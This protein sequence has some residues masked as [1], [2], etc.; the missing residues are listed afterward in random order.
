MRIGLFAV[1]A[2]GA[3]LVVAPE[4]ALGQ[5]MFKG[6]GNSPQISKPAPPPPALPGATPT[7][8]TPA[9]ASRVPTDMAPAEA[10]FDAINRGDIETARDAIGRG[11]DLQGH[12][13]LG[14]TPIELSIDLG[15]NDISFMLLSMRGAEAPPSRPAPLTTAAKPAPTRS[16]RQ[17]PPQPAP[18]VAG[19]PPSSQTARLFS[20]DGGAPNPNAGFLGFD[21]GRR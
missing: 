2:A 8:R 11:A 3:A 9:P 13:V 5:A 17:A 6:G 10:L 7:G 14:M 1:V 18:R 20:G 4:V 21:S 19:S 12:N 15:R 16:A